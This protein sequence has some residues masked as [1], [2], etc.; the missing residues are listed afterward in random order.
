MWPL[1]HRLEVR[2][3]SGWVRHKTPGKRGC[4]RASE[5]VL[6]AFWGPEML[7]VRSPVQEGWGWTSR[8]L[9][10]GVTLWAC[11]AL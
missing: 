10:R 3:L 11:P 9:C 8:S 6:M 1:D 4:V 7:R 2:I 5:E